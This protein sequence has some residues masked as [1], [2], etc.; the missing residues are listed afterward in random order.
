M[1]KLAIITTH[2]I[3]YNAPWFRLLAE[4]KKIQIRVYYTW[5]QVQHGQKFDPGFGKNIQWDLPLLEGYEYTFVEN[6]SKRP[7]SKSFRG[8]DNPTLIREIEDWRPDAMLVFGWKFKSHLKAMRYFHGRIPVLF[9]GDSNLLDKQ[10]FRKRQ[11]R[12]VILRN[13]FKNVDFALYVGRANKAY[14]E[15]AGLK[16]DQ[17]VFAPH[18]IDNDRFSRAEVV[19][20]PDW[21]SI[22]DGNLVFLFAG[23]LERKKNPEILLK[24]FKELIS[25]AE[26]IVV[27]NGPLERELKGKY[28]NCS[29]I[30]FLNFQNQ[31]IMPSVYK[32]TDVFVLPSGGPGETWGLAVNEA[33][34]CGKPVLVSDACGCAA[35]LVEEGVTGYT[36][37]SGNREDLVSK[38]NL[39]ISGKVDLKKMGENAFSRIGNYNFRNI[40]E[41]VENLVHSL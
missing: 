34:A 32:K 27:G 26:L 24:S 17:L 12:R 33:M 7:G 6:V 16:N 3:Q 14:F 28:Q 29:N 8:I 10:S 30:H 36:F 25:K 38:I 11:L 19:E 2:P 15:H 20:I 18:A 41:P 5:S 37:R 31:Q 35:D 4:R 1:N 23:K 22:P 39:M 9:R 21:P 13:I 40:V